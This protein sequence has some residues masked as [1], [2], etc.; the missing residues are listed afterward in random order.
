MRRSERSREQPAAGK[1][2]LQRLTP[3]NDEGLRRRLWSIGVLIMVGFAMLLARTWQLQVI[4]G[5]QFLRLSEQNRLR[6]RQMK[7][8]RGRILDRH[9]RI[10]AD[11]RPAYA[12]LAMS[13]D[14]PPAD[15]LRT[16]LRQL[17]I[18]IEPATSNP[19]GPR[20]LFNP[21]R[22]NRMSTATRWRILP[23]IG[24][25]FQV[26]ISMWSPCGYI[27]INRLPPICS[28]ILAR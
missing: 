11:N 6:D 10:L 17:D 5:A 23:N 21:S 18:A 19:C 26:S 15:I 25:I 7:S 14:L 22:S 4:E 20:R 2:Y 8:L 24:W 13:E 27:R 16:S 3:I 9:G 28:A 1:T 12:L